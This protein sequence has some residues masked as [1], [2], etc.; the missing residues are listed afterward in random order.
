[1]AGKR[2]G[3]KDVRALDEG[4]IIWDG[5]V[6]GFGRAARKVIALPTC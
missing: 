4:D 1:M 6:P 5:T 3:L 2:I